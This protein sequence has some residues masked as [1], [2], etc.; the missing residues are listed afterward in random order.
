MKNEQQQLLE[1]IQ[2]GNTEQAKALALGNNDLLSERTEGGVSMLMLAIYHRKHEIVDEFLDMGVEPDLFESAALGKRERVKNLINFRPKLA[3]TFSPDGFTP[4][5]LACFFGHAEVVEYL[6]NN[7]AD[8][9]LGAK[10]SMRVHPIHSA[11]AVRDRDLSLRIAEM[12]L[13]A[14][15]DPNVE[16]QGG[17]TPLHAAAAHGNEQMIDLLVD[18]GAQIDVKNGD[19]KTPADL[20]HSNGYKNLAEKLRDI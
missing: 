10:N 9:N 19:G 2:N 13:D 11:V 17:I 3:N 16:Q 12:L 14:G 18:H 20:A 4:L 15:A 1:A 8:P 7:G 5:G 6:L